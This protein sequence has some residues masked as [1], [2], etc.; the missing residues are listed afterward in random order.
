MQLYVNVAARQLGKLPSRTHDV[1]FSAVAAN[2][3]GQRSPPITLPR[4]SPVYDVFEKVSHPAGTDGLGHPVYFRIAFEQSVPHSRHS[5]E[6]GL[7]GVI[8]KRSVA[9]PTEGIAVNVHLLLEKQAPLSEIFDYNGVCLFAENTF[10][11]SRVLLK[12]SPFVHQ[13][14]ERQLIPCS[15]LGVV[16][17]ESGRD[18]DDA[19]SVGKRHVSVAGDVIGVFNPCPVEHGLIFFAFKLPAKNLFR[20]LVF[21]KQIVRKRFGKPIKSVVRLDFDIAF[22]RIDAQRHVARQRPG[23]GCPHKEKR[24]FLS[25][26]G[27]FDVNGFFLYLLV[28]LRHLMA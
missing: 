6:P 24:V 16:L 23:S 19:A 9:S 5:Y 8:Q 10:Q 11:L 20:H 17:A 18:M 2:P 12:A 1:Y 7:A 21:F 3:Y 13:L 22:L 15:D 27:E 4:N 25:G 14:H 26:N 28:A